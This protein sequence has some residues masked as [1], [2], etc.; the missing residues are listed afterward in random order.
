MDLS[1]DLLE[2]EFPLHELSL[3][4]NL[5]RSLI[6]P[7]VDPPRWRE[8]TERVTPSLQSAMKEKSKRAL[9]WVSNFETLKN[10]TNQTKSGDGSN[11]I[12]ISTIS[13]IEMISLLQKNLL[14]NL[15]GIIRNESLLNS[16]N[17]LSSLALEYAGLHEV[18]LH[19]NI[20]PN[21]LSRN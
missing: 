7:N 19:G 14:E 8:E 11:E 18:F 20:C 3:S 9:G 10:Y 17:N 2:R 21:C 16:N 4:A 5:Q 13:L 12:D 6:M 1:T 15:S